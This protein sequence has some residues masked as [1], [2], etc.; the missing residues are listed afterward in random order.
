MITAQAVELRVGARVLLEEATF[1]IAAGD[2]IGLVGRNGAGKTTLT[3]TLAGETLP[4]GGQIVRTGEVGYLPQDPRTGDLD[5]IAMDRVLSARGLDDV[6]RGMRGDRGRD[7]ERRRRDREAA[8]E[9]YSTLE[10]RFTAAG[11]YAAE[12][13]ASRI[14]SNLGLDERVLGQTIG[15]LS[16][17]QRRRV[18]LA[19]IL[20]S[21]VE[22]LLLDEPTNHLD[23][24]SI[25]WLRDYL[26]SYPG[27]FVVISHDT[28]LLR[29]TVNKVFHL[30]AN[31]GELD[32]YN[33]GWD[34][35]LQ[36][37]ET[38]EKRRKRERANTE[39][40][41]SVLLAQADKMR[42]KATKAVA[43]QNMAR[44]AERML[45]SLG[46]GPRVGQGGAPALP[47]AGAVRQDAAD[48]RRA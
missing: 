3:K 5:M 30:D 10:A 15:T 34:A 9:R 27:G 13:E 17:G 8:M 16:G 41:A 6:V 20:F 46:G 1:R 18:E 38:D 33:L 14:A 2:R 43:A 37:R 36:Q 39:K 28:D 40:K 22:T 23:A 4:T 24:D 42:A 21:G 48:R 32:Q 47:D 12:S 45:S 7:G 35:Y 19:R 26:R 29:A 25:L 44:R 31:R 11:G